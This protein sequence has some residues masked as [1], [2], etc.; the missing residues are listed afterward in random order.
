ML[1][2][3]KRGEFYHV[4]GT[5]RVGNKTIKVKERSTGF[6]KASD[7]KEYVAHLE[8]EIV[9]SFLRPEETRNKS[10][11]FD[12]CL[13][14]YM[15]EKTITIP[16][17]QKIKVLIEHFESV[18]VSEIPQKWNVFCEIKHNMSEGTL[19]RYAS[20]M[21]AI[22]NFS[23]ERLNIS[24]KLIKRIPV[25]DAIVFLLP[26]GVKEK[27]LSCYSDK[28]R[29]M[30]ITLAYQGM[31]E[32][33]CL[34]LLWED[35]HLKEKMIVIRTSKNGETRA[36]PM[37]PKVWWVLARRWIKMGKPTTGA[38]WLTI[39]NKPYRDGRKLGG[40]GTLLNV[41][42]RALR[43]LKE[44]YGID[45][46]MRIHDW[47]HDWAS[48]MVMAGVDLLTVQKL[49]GWKSLDMVKRYAT[50]SSKHETDAINMI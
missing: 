35:I 11:K 27:L 44:R 34:H 49:G 24:P 20:A 40:G 47:R 29:P 26:E 28:I 10:I 39:Y 13:K 9:D 7:A 21:N 48:R 25:N 12:D 46:K 30:F 23:K 15:N 41:H 8:K 5:V 38:V 2:I 37:H 3:R 33:E 1:N 18:P 50:F 31:R 22:L 4:R 6:C 19:N 42:N 17:F 36:I 45:I 14:V 32:S 16:Q 43:K